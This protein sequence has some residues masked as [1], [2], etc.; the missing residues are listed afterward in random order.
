MCKA[1]TILIYLIGYEAT[2]DTYGVILPL[3]IL[4]V[5]CPQA[6][7]AVDAGRKGKSIS[8]IFLYFNEDKFLLPQ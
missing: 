5:P 7:C 8:R 1:T 3:P 6:F 2:T 4:N